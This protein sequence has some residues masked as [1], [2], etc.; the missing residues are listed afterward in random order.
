MFTEWRSM[1]SS[2]RKISRQQF[3]KILNWVIKQYEK[4]DRLSD[5]LQEY[6]GD[7][8]FTGFFSAQWDFVVE[9]LADVVNDTDEW[10]AWWMWEAEHGTA[11]QYTIEVKGDRIFLNDAGELYD[12]MKVHYGWKDE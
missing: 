2:Q 5:A 11:E 12:F 7:K 8:D 3:T 9:W 6:T 4:S 10:I 1:A